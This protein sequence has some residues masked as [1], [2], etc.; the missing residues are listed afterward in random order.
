[1]YS[2]VSVFFASDFRKYIRTSHKLFTVFLKPY[3]LAFSGNVTP[4]AKAPTNCST[5]G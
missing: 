1:M 3:Y 4:T 5:D 2:V